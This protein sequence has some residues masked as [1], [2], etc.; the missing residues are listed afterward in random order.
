MIYTYSPTLLCCS[1]SDTVLG[2]SGFH[3]DVLTL[4]KNINARLKVGELSKCSVHV[5][6]LLMSPENLGRIAWHAEME[7]MNNSVCNSRSAN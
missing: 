4:T 6:V 5:S 2:C 1:T 7:I 3:G